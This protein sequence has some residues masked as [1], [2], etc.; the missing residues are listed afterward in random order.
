VGVI[1]ITGEN[2]KK[3]ETFIYACAAFGIGGFIGYL[4]G[5]KA[6]IEERIKFNQEVQDSLNRKRGRA[7][8]LE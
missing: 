7:Q 5:Y 3:M 8:T 4:F 2:R 1:S 6:A